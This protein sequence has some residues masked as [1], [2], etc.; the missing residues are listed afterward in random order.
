MIMNTRWDRS[1]ACGDVSLVRNHMTDDTVGASV[2]HLKESKI[3]TEIF[4]LQ[5]VLCGDDFS[6]VRALI[7]TLHRLWCPGRCV[8]VSSG[9]AWVSMCGGSPASRVPVLPIQ[10]IWYAVL[11]VNVI[12]QRHTPYTVASCLYQ[13]PYLLRSSFELYSKKTRG[14]NNRKKRKK[15]TR[16]IESQEH[17]HGSSMTGIFPFQETLARLS[18]TR[19]LQVQEIR[20]QNLVVRRA[21]VRGELETVLYI[22]T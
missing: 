1:F 6:Q 14:T 8:S 13:P 9:C 22:Q 4:W 5:K 19:H 17:G 20:I 12:H 18:N 10:S 11:L 16:T 15:K 3:V 2:Q 7:C 21:E